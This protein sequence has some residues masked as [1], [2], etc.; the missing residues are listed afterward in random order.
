MIKERSVERRDYVMAFVT[1]KNEKERDELLEV[2]E[3]SIIQR[4]W[5]LINNVF[6]QTRRCLETFNPE[7]MDTESS[8]TAEDPATNR[9]INHFKGLAALL[10][11]VVECYYEESVKRKEI[12]EFIEEIDAV[13]AVEYLESKLVKKINGNYYVKVRTQKG[14]IVKLNLGPLHWH[15]AHDLQNLIEDYGD[16]VVRRTNIKLTRKQTFTVK[17]YRMKI[18]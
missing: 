12:A 18:I 1:A 16:I 8:D 5:E 4:K 17:Q 6:D 14:E 3:S 11:S 7:T 2:L 10:N 15:A 9:L 13:K